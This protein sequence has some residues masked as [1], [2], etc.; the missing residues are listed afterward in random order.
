MIPTNATAG[1][2]LVVLS[3]G[4][5]ARLGSSKAMARIRGVTLLRRT[6]RTLAPL[7]AARVIVV[8]PPRAVRAR[9]ELRGERVDVAVSRRRSQGL[10]ASVRTGLFRAR[11]SAA[12]LILPVDLPWL[13]RREIARLIARWRASRRSV[14]ARRVG[15]RAGT[16]LVLPRRLYARAQRIGADLGLRNLVN[17]LPEDELELVDLPSAAL[18]VDTLVDLRQ[19]RRRLRAF[20]SGC[21]RG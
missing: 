5:S 12:V 13:E 17:G 1:V 20:A 7:A 9:A 2:R 16:P 21:R 8:L 19:A 14:V 4:F 10:S 11:Y 6:V 3:A 15:D 18:D